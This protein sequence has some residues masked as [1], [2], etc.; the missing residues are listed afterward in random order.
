MGISFMSTMTSRLIEIDGSFGEGGGQII[1][2]SLSLSVITG[3]SFRITDIRSGRRNPGLRAQH[4]AAVEASAK[5]SRATVEGAFMGSTE[6]RF[7]P[8]PIQSGRY[9]FKI[10]KPLNLGDKNGRFSLIFSQF[11]KVI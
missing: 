2:S 9:R 8:G 11:Q 6:L 4:L 1:R 3:K 10:K 5:I 7:R